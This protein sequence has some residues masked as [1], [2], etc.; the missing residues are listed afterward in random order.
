MRHQLVLCKSGVLT[1][2]VTLEHL[3]FTSWDTLH[4]TDRH[5]KRADNEVQLQ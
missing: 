4:W 3:I 2:L 5:A 1:H